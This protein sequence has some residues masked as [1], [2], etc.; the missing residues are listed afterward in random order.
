MGGEAHVLDTKC[1]EATP[2]CNVTTGT[3]HKQGIVTSHK[4]PCHPP[5]DSKGT[6][7]LQG[8]GTIN[9][10]PPEKSGSIT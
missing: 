5:L 4:P 9:N 2:E 10:R 7:Q 3:S 1:K 6:A 8:G